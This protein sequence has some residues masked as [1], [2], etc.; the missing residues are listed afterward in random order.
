MSR[1]IILFLNIM[2]IL[3]AEDLFSSGSRR[4][5]KGSNFVDFRRYSKLQVSS[6]VKLRLRNQHDKK[7]FVCVPK[8]SQALTIVRKKI[9]FKR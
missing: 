3:F 8:S 2:F 4:V 5:D 1:F 9:Y 6:A 7:I